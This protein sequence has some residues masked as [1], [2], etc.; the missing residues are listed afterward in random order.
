MDTSDC[1][2]HYFDKA[3]DESYNSLVL[4]C[5]RHAMVND[6]KYKKSKQVHKW[7]QAGVYHFGAAFHYRKENFD[8]RPIPELFLKL[9]GVS[10]FCV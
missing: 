3:C 6:R 9:K 5:I 8:A 10:T 7:K 2:L 4:D 1:V